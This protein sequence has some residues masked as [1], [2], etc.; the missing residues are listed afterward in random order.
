MRYA[1][2]DEKTGAVVNVVELDEGSEWPPPAGCA[3]RAST[4]ADPGDSFNGDALIKKPPPEPEPPPPPPTLDDIYDAVLKNERGF[5]ALVLA[6][7][8]GSF[9][10]G[11]NRTPAQLRA[12][13][14]AKL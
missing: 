3:L 11:S 6:L 4:A 5:K 1:V 2:V 14:K 13:I 9:V 10:P 12:I 7:N 8:D